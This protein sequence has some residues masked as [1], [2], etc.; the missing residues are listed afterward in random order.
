L[1]D[2]EIYSNFSNV[3]SWIGKKHR[4]E[5]VRL[6]EPIRSLAWRYL[7]E[8]LL[9]INEAPVRIDPRFGRP[10]P[11]LVFWFASAFGMTDNEITRRLALSLSYISLTVSMRD[12]LLDERAPPIEALTCLAN[13]YHYEYFKIFKA[14]FPHRSDFW[15]VLSNCS[16]EW[17]KYEIW[18]SSFNY[19][20]KVLDPFSEQFLKESSRYL[21]AITLPTLAAIAILTHNEKKIATITRFL[22]N[23]WM[24]WRIVDD[25]RDWHEDLEI[26]NFNHSS[27]LYH[28]LSKVK[29]PSKFG[30]EHAINMF[31]DV[32][33]INTI[34][35][36]V[37]KYYMI[38][39]KNASNFKCPYLDKFLDT[40]IAFHEDE[41]NNLLRSRSLFYERL[42][43]LVSK[44]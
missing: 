3:L 10:I 36:G 26:R 38:A 11:Y 23:Y 32:D 24:G 27:V 29:D 33:S 19:Q 39:K 15:Y 14:I 35:G 30:R 21:V 43:Q 13:I 9:V 2:N 17:S 18:R 40:Q 25:I 5:C 28:S 37:H 8:R 44:L 4:Q 41:K 16:N 7:S 20:N 22:T 34:Y 42:N 6:P 12:D 1:S 31:L